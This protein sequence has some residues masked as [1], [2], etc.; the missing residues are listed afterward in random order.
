MNNSIRRLLLSAPLLIL[1]LAAQALAKPVGVDVARRVAAAQYSIVR[2][3]AAE[4]PSVASAEFTL[5]FQARTVAAADTVTAYYVFNAPDG[6]FVI[7]AGDDAVT[8]VLGYS[9]EGAFTMSRPSPQF[10]W[11][12]RR[13]E[14]QIADVIASR[15]TAPPDVQRNWRELTEPGR[16]KRSGASA[17]SAAVGPL[18][19]TQWDQAPYYNALCPF[20]AAANER[21]VTGCVA[22]AI[23]QIMKYHGSPARGNGDH[24][25]S[26]Q[27]YGYLYANFAN[28]TYEWGSM[29]NRVTG[30]N[31]AVA[32]L[33]YHVGV[34]CEMSYGPSASGGSGAYPSEAAAALVRYF[35]YRNTTR[36]VERESYSDNAWAALIRSEID[37]GRPVEYH[38]FGDGSGHSFI[39]DGY[40]GAYFHMNWG[41]DGSYNGNF[42]LSNLA[43]DGVGTGGGAGS[44][45][46]AQ[47]AIIGIAPERPV[48][49]EASIAMYTSLSVTPNPVTANGIVT[50][51]YNVSNTG[52]SDFS[53]DY[54]V[55]LFDGSGAFVRYLGGIR[56]GMSLKANYHYTNSLTDDDT[57]FGVS[58]GTYYAA[59][60]WRP[61]GKEWIVAAAGS[62]RNSATLEVRPASYPSD[63]VIYAAPTTTPTVLHAGEPFT[64]HTDF[65]NAGNLDFTG[66]I[67][68]FAYTLDGESE[69]GDVAI[70]EN[71]QLGAGNHWINGLTFECSGLA[72]QPGRYL[73]AFFNRPQGGD[74]EF[75]NPGNYVNP[76]IVDILPSAITADRYEPN[77]AQ[78]SA[79]RLT[80]NYSGSNGTANTAGSNIHEGSNYDYYRIDLA[81]G[82]T[83]DLAAFV[84]DSWN[85]EAGGY[86]NDVSVMWNAGDGWSD[87]YDDTTDAFRVEGG[88]AVIFKVQPLYTGTIG[89]YRLDIGARRTVSSVEPDAAPAFALSA[90]P[91]PASGTLYVHLAPQAGTIASLRLVDALG[92]TVWQGSNPSGGQTVQA[93]VG[94]V[95]S[96][97]YTLV[98]ETSRGLISRRIIVQH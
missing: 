63:L 55:A 53:G 50:V 31:Q 26:H 22:T 93:D 52:T 30:P 66:D 86:T 48:A 90:Y 2:S 60:Y 58:P 44:Y 42:L 94:G 54:C 73:F 29:P 3:D 27:R 56:S 16:S 83:Y 7:V 91:S 20:D 23:A 59:V 85:D 80:L 95:P 79:F 65:A 67:G 49:G 46:E 88:R 72:V 77:D 75:V 87:V 78:G 57:L 41:W 68:V 1:L 24:G 70:R 13:Y 97:A 84:R 62:Q 64:L 96:G 17:Q 8:P 33:M 21:T 9:T 82:Y 43:P 15:R 40:D 81:S 51:A 11:W 10:T 69:V 89:T 19:K 92:A 5:A 28:A 45:N 47:G 35:G 25:Y 61:A 18:V 32:Q 71:L 6:G 34:A 12:M 98:A 14:R 37:N 4:F 76:L 36:T 74:W 38:G 39:C